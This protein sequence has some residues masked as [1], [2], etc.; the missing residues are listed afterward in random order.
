MNFMAQRMRR[1]EF[2]HISGNVHPGLVEHRQV[3]LKH[4]IDVYRLCP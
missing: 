1:D 3:R 2:W 4:S